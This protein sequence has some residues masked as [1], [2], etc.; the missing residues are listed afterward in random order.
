MVVG[1]STM[2]IETTGVLSAMTV[3]AIVAGSVMTGVHA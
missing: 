3:V 1:C 2:G